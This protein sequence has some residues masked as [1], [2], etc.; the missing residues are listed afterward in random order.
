MWLKQGQIEVECEDEN[1]Y[2][3]G[4]CGDACEVAISNDKTSYVGELTRTHL[5]EQG[6]VGMTVMTGIDTDIDHGDLLS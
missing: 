3:T 5:V 1:D 4:E 2:G 6:D